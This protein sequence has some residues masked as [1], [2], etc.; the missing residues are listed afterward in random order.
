[1]NFRFDNVLSR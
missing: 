1:M